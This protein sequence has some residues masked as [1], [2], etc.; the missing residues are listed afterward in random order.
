M[1]S[2]LYNPK[3]LLVHRFQIPNV[4]P[5]TTT[6]SLQILTI[7]Q[8]AQYGIVKSDLTIRI[9]EGHYNSTFF[10]LA[11]YTRYCG[12]GIWCK[13]GDTSNVLLSCRIYGLLGYRFHISGVKFH[14]LSD[15]PR[16]YISHTKPTLRLNCRWL[17]STIRPL[18]KCIMISF[19]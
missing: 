13:T 12:Y 2:N 4:Q 19:G 16:L 6:I 8:T 5:R 3:N 9:E 1:L 17:Y 18:S 15:F 10:L 11:A 7:Y 14:F